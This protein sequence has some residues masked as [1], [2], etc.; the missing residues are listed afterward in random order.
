MIALLL[1]AVL[2][3]TGVG[4]V[5]W[6]LA[7]PAASRQ[8]RVVRRQLLR[9]DRRVATE[10]RHARQAMNDAAGQAWRNRFE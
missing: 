2:A 5:V 4:L 1:L 3:A 6:S 10:H 7:E 8:Q 9:A